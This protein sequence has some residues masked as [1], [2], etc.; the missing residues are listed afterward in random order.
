MYKEGKYKPLSLA[1]SILWAKEVYKIFEA[2]N[3]KVIRMGLHPSEGIL[4]GD[5]LI[6]G[7]F[8]VSYREQVMTEI[9]WDELKPLLNSV[10]KKALEIAVHPT[11]LNYAIG[12]EARN[13][14]RLLAD[15]NFVTFIKD[16]S[17]ENRNYY[18]NTD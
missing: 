12:Y 2:A 7:P 14:K 15:Y 1:E 6:D 9:W 3:V 13:K 16:D 4:C 18:V 5:D 10:K 17:L 8:H 11:Q